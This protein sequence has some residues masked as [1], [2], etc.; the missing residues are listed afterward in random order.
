MQSINVKHYELRNQITHRGKSCTTDEA[1]SSTRI[2]EELIEYV[3]SL[4]K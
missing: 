1:L 2:A 3:V 4:V